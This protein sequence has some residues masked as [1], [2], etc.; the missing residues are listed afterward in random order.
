MVLMAFA[1]QIF[2]SFGLYSP[3]LIGA[4]VVLIVGWL[5]A[6]IVSSII[7][8]ALQRTGMDEK[9]AR[10]VVGEQKAQGMQPHRWISKIIYYVLL[11]FVFVAFFQ[12]LGLTLVAEPLNQLLTVVFSYLPKLFA[13]LVIAVIAWI[14]ATVL[15]KIVLRVL[16]TAKVDEGL[17][18]KTGLDKTDMP[19][20]QTIAEI[21]FFLV[22]LLFLP[23]ILNALALCGL[24]EPLQLMIGKI[25]G[26]LPNLLAAAIILI[27]G[28]FIA[29]ILQ[30]IITNLLIAMGSERLSEKVGLAKVLGSQGLAGL[31]GLVVYILVLLP[32]L[33]AALQALAID[34]ITLPVS[35]MLAQMLAILPNL[36]GAALVLAVAYILGKIIAELAVKLLAGLGFDS[37]PERLGLARSPVEGARTPSQMVGYIVIAAIMLFAL[38]EA[39]QILKFALLADIIYEFT[40]F[41]GHVLMG[42]IIFAI[43][44]YLANIAFNAV[45]SSGMSSSKLPAHAARISI[46]AFAGAMALRQMGLANE[47]INLAFGLLLGAIAVAV[48]LAFGLGGKEIAAQEIKKWLEG[49]K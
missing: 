42:L 31:I 5:V 6:L 41:A 14:I 19:L 21:V 43:G 28:W 15:K 25:L 44:I 40:I 17:G 35:N 49:M 12:V 7:G 24:L 10:K 30:K 20:S 23:M 36:F 27:I 1:D 4:L 11:F 45:I 46:L 18:S 37:L 33:I 39:A 34:A 48:A 22:L 29:R 9:I 3:N 26:F 47:I 13:A 8:K 38:I 16:M 2:H 32:V